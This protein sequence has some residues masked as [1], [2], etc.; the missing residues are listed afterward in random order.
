MEL[1]V[2]SDEYFMR[3]ALRQAEI[4]YD[5]GEI[6]V[7]AIVVCQK[8]IIAKAYNQ[9]EKLNDVTAHAE[10]LA[11]TAAANHL[12]GKYLTDCTL[13][14]SLEPCGMCA[15]ALNWSQISEIVYALEDE[16]R[17]FTKINPH[18]VHSKTKVRSGLMASESKK[19]LDNFFAR[20]RDRRN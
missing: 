4:A 16:K 13:Y 14:V 1:T 5:E 11:I 9:T 18:M 2:N 10:M 17:G 12:G 19:I 15:G 8:K 3:E 20:L 6:P 7:G